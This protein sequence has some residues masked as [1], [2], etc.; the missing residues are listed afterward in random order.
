MNKT[1]AAFVRMESSFLALIE[2]TPE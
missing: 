2:I 1:H